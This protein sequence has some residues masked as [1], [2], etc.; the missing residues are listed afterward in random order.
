MQ[1][2]ANPTIVGFALFVSY[3]HDFP[4]KKPAHLTGFVFA[5]L[6]AGFALV[7][8]MGGAAQTRF[9][10]SLNGIAG[11]SSFIFFEVFI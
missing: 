10:A 1:A 9:N 11:T 4:N 7:F 5:V 3:R 8:G 2:K 6:T